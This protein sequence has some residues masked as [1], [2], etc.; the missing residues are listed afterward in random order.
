MNL[1][2]PIFP[3]GK[4]LYP[5]LVAIFLFLPSKGTAADFSGDFSLAAGERY[6]DNLFLGKNERQG[7]FVTLIAPSLDLA[8]SSK[9][10][11]ARL[12]YSPH[13]SFYSSQNQ[14]NDT[15]HRLSANLDVKPSQLFNFNIKDEYIRSNETNEQITFPGVGPI[16]RLVLLQSNVA[17]ADASY[18]PVRRIELGLSGSFFYSQLDTTPQLDT[19]VSTLSGSIKYLSRPTTSYFISAGTSHF[20]FD[21]EPAAN[22]QSYQVGIN[23]KF[24]PTLISELSGG[25]EFTET[26]GGFSHTDFTGRFAL[27]KQTPRGNYSIIL[28]R[29]SQA[30]IESQETVTD[31][32]LKLLASHELT[33]RLTLSADGLLNRYQSFNGPALKQTALAAITNLEYKLNPLTKIAV[34]YDFIYFKDDI[35]SS[36]NYHDNIVTVSF[37]F[38]YS[39]KKSKTA[40]AP[41]PPAL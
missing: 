11:T 8:L 10:I 32:S 7:D 2:R 1:I 19:H 6:N 23:H 31:T 21:R 40:P 22:S 12:S 16:R 38:T 15:E 26:E 24:T 17:S 36:N 14:L 37:V 28:G 13:F 35:N 34:S 4:S 18:S 9:T 25:V 29:S 3:I 39:A 30:A 41:Q 20:G 27:I 5:L 33:K